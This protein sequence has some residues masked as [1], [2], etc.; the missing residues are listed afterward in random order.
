[1][2]RLKPCLLFSIC[3]CLVAS[4]RPGPSTIGRR[5]DGREAPPPPTWLRASDKVPC[6]GVVVTWKAVTNATGYQV[7]RSTTAEPPEKPFVSFDRGDITAWQD[8]SASPEIVYWYWA[9]TVRNTETSAY[10]QP[11]SGYRSGFVGVPIDLQ[12][13]EKAT[14]TL[15]VRWNRV[16]NATGYEVRHNVTPVVLGSSIIGRTELIYFDHT[17]G[18]HQPQYYWVRSTNRCYQSEWSEMASGEAP[19]CR[20]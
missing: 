12:V 19:R 10:S 9:K 16:T 7:F 1:M 6:E 3:L 18:S 2:K 13:S 8:T 14:C 20:K 4:C 17:V 5:T 15:R 11:D